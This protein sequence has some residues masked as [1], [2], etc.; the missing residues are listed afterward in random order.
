MQKAS[1]RISFLI[2]CAVVALAPL[3]FGST[4]PIAVAIWC[5]ALGA[6]LIFADL[7]SLRRPQL[8]CLLPLVLLLA[9]FLG[10][11]HAQ[12]AE[13][14][15]F[16]APANPIWQQ[17]SDLLQRHLEAARTVVRDQPFFAVGP[18][19][20]AILAMV[21]GFIVG[22]DRYRAHQLL[23]VIAWSGAAYAVIAIVS[24]VIDPTKLFWRDKI[25]YTTALTTPFVNRNAAAMYY[26]TCS[27][28]SSLLFWEF[29][30][31]RLPAGPLHVAGLWHAAMREAPY[32]MAKNGLPFAV[33]L[34]A[35]L[36][37]GSRAGVVLAMIGLVLG[38][39]LF[40]WRDMP[41]RAGPLTA[42]AVGGLITLVFLQTLGGNVSNRFNESG[43]TDPG[44]M[45]T[46]RAIIRMIG[47]RPWLGTGL[48]TFAWSFPP[49]RTGNMFGIWDRAHNTFL[50]FAVE[51]GLLL[52]VAIA[53]GWLF[54]LIILIRG[55]KT[56]RRDTTLP[57]AALTVAIICLLHSLIDF[58]LQI[59]GFA[60]L[61]FA[62]TGAGAAQSFAT[63]RLR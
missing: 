22:V 51:G 16:G 30:R 32:V 31:A 46:Y 12:V 23:R 53:A 38:F 49:Y 26:G 33:C 55:V 29:F 45:E 50:E 54:I 9:V 42:I 61:V 6:G 48:G 14:P 43:L 5:I 18:P 7:E 35:T 36:L 2:L 10:V 52:A 28:V 62:L 59:P 56:R 8:A 25:A 40:F 27:V 3:P 19:L 17:A 1:N 11:L 41:R 58:S 24:Y 63:R 13:H 15:W 37:T 60:I 57:V 4:D 44:R 39:T 34:L 47:D 20:A 21:I